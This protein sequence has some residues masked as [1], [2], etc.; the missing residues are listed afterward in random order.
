MNNKIHFHSIDALRFFAFLKVYFLH[1]PID[2][3]FPIL[4]FLKSGGGIGVSFFF[5]LSGFLISYLLGHEKHN[6]NKINLKNFFIR[7]S[8]RIWPLFYLMVI[9]GFLLPYSF[10]QD[11]GFHMIGGGYELDWMYSF[12]FL[13][14][15][16]M[17]IEDSFP[18]TTPL[19]VFWSLCIEE[20]FYLIWLFAFYLIPFKHIPKFLGISVSISWL[21][22]FFEVVFSNNNTIFQMDVFTNLDYFAIGGILGYLV[23]INYEQLSRAILSISKNIRIGYIL[24]VLLIIVF[25]NIV[26]PYEPKSIFFIFRPTVIAILFTLLIAVFIPKDSSIAINNKLLNYLGKISYGLYV[27]HIIFIHICYKYCLANNI[28][29]D[30]FLSIGIT[31]VITF[32]GSVLLSILSYHYF[33]KPF[34]S[35]RDRITKAKNI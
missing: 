29:I 21:S 19:S 5:V 11:I 12:T 6:T 18:K 33:E 27:Y 13:E 2:G 30:S 24:F 8:L 34:L 26:L 25:Q 15:Y 23:V 20:H 16:K 17:I 3:V 1:F 14:N 7:R 22:R 4:Q 9:M 32:G 31:F 10:K 28:K 35:L